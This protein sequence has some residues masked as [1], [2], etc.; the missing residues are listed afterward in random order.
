MWVELPPT[1]R[2]VMERGWGRGEG[3]KKKNKNQETKKPFEWSMQTKP[4][5]KHVW[6]LLWYVQ[7]NPY[8]MENRISFWFFSS[9]SF[10]LLRYGLRDR[11]NF[12]LPSNKKA[13][14]F[15]TTITDAANFRAK[16]TTAKYSWK[17][18]DII[19][20]KFKLLQPVVN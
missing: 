6:C 8:T 1:A 15:L 9:S 12:C 18:Y 14:L 3:E 20:M 19:V 2:K 13:Q 4:T 11:I 7:T 16:T 17:R 10:F 5:Y